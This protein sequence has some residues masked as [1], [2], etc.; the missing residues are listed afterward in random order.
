M[1]AVTLGKRAL[2]FI[3]KHKQSEWSGAPESLRAELAAYAESRSQCHIVENCMS[4]E[5]A[6]AQIDD[7]IRD[8]GIKVAIIDYVQCLKAKGKDRYEQVTNASIALRSMA[9]DRKLLIIALCHLNRQIEGRKKFI[10]VMADLKDSGQLEQDADVV[11]FLVWPWRLDSKQ[12]PDHFQIFVAKNRN[13]GIIEPV[14]DCE[15]NAARQTVTGEKPANY[16]TGLSSWESS[17]PWGG[18]NERDF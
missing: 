12:R 15:F 16:D 9:H 13:R 7:A 14:V 2:Q 11:L 5:M 18:S 17:E 1:P 4:V 3:S 10:P 8:H 6:I